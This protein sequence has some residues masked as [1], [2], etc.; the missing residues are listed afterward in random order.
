[1]RAEQRLAYST[2]YNDSVELSGEFEEFFRSYTD[3]SMTIEQSEELLGRI[4]PLNDTLGSDVDALKLIGPP[5]AVAMADALRGTWLSVELAIRWR[6]Q[7]VCGEREVEKNAG[8]C[9]GYIGP[10]G[11]HLDNTTIAQEGFIIEARKSLGVEGSLPATV[12]SVED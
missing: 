5:E 11:L 1:M 9:E 6:N 3:G 8:S 10:V 7:C 12:K 2:V 4:E